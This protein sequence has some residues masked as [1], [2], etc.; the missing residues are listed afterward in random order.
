[1]IKNKEK[2][3]QENTEKI[4][5]I[6]KIYIEEMDT[7]SETNEFTIDNIEKL[8]GE[9]DVYAKEVYREINREVIAQINE[10]EIIRSKKGN[11]KKR[12]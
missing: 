12:V 6:V 1:L 8:W 2:I 10:K 3:I 7:L 5:Q 4:T 9:M 11:T